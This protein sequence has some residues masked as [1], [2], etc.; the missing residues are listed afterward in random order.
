MHLPI[1]AHIVSDSGYLHYVVVY[2]LRKTSVV[3]GDPA[4][5]LVKIK[6]CQFYKQWTGIMIDYKKSIDYQYDKVDYVAKNAI[7]S[8]L[9][10]K[11]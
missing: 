10:K 4:K 2:G 9:K 11:R 7:Q 8:I 5:G 3:I 1:V 6:K